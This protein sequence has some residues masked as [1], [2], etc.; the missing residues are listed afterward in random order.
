MCLTVVYVENLIL[1]HMT[2]DAVQIPVALFG[3]FWTVVQ[4]KTCSTWENSRLAA[5]HVWKGPELGFGLDIVFVI[6]FL[7]FS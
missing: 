1:G 3:P 5:S 4:S 7:P 2:F 6:G